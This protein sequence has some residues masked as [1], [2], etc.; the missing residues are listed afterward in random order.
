VVARTVDAAVSRAA[1]QTI[2]VPASRW[3]SG[4]EV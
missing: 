2:D 1:G 3:A 4:Q